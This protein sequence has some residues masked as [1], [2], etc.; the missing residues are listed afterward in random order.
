MTWSSAIAVADREEI[1]VEVA[2]RV[3]ALDRPE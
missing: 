1:L 2:R 3:T